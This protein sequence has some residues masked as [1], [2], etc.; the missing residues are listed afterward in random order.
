MYTGFRPEFLITKNIEAATNWIMHDD[1][2]PGYNVHDKSLRP[3]GDAASEA[4]NEVDFL[5]NGFKWR[6]N[7][8]PNWDQASNQSGEAYLYYAV[9]ETPFKTTNAR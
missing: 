6:G 1:K 3:D 4:N 5:S 7:N 2:R 9:A 8:Y